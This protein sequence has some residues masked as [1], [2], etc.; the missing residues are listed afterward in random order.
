MQVRRLLLLVAATVALVFLSAGPSADSALA[1]VDTPEAPVVTV[2]QVEA[3]TNP[4]EAKENTG[5]SL[6]LDKKDGSSAASQPLTIVLLLTLVSIVPA[7]LILMTS[8]TRIVIVLGLTRNALNL[9]GVPPNQVLIGLALFLTL[10]VMG[11]V[12]SK[13]NAQAIQPFM[14]GEITQ[15]QAFE[16]GMKPMRSFMLKQ[17]RQKDVAMFV[18]L[19]GEKRP[20]KQSDVSNTTLIPAFVIGELRAAFIIGFV[21]FI[22]F[23]VIDMVISASLMSMGMVMLPPV[24]ISLPFKLLLFV[25]MDGWLLVVQSLV[26]SFV[27]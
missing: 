23:L 13:V 24:L 16:E 11:P 17:A 12:F 18:K 4:G 22:P 9:N 25:V 5:I 19:S 27:T 14:K 2:P 7:L 8:F 6:N 1:Q 26:K 10:F 21:I 15:S 20:A 3:P